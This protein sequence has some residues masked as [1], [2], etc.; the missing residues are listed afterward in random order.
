MHLSPSATQNSRSGKTM[1]LAYTAKQQ[2]FRAELRQWLAANVPAS[3]LQS[4]DTAEGFAQHRQ[5]AV[6]KQRGPACEVARGSCDG[7]DVGGHGARARRQQGPSL[8]DLSARL[9]WA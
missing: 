8:I 5:A 4:F 6:L 3:P 7:Q 2:A 1:D 9:A